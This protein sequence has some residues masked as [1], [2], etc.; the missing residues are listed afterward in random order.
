MHDVAVALFE[1]DVFEGYAKL[2]RE[3]LCEWRGVALP[4]VERAG[5]QSHR[6]VIFEHDLAEFD[7]GRR[8]DFEVRADGDAAQLAPLAAFFL[9]LGYIGVIGY[10]E[11][12]VEDAL[13]IAAVV[14]DAG[15]SRERHLRRLDEISFP[16][17]Q[18]VD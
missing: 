1:L 12:L 9:A 8:R 2:R 16:Q 13:E 7:A 14:G 15:G 4:I 6:A 5:D 10:L 3:H 11:L 18:A 17:R